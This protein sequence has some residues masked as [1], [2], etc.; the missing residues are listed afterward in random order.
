[1]AVFKMNQSDCR[2]SKT[3]WATIPVQTLEDTTI[4]PRAHSLLMW[5]IA[6][7]AL[8]AF[9]ISHIAKQFNVSRKAVSAWTTELVKAEY[10]DRSQVQINGRYVWSYYAYPLKKPKLD[11]VLHTIRV[12]K[13]AKAS[14]RKHSNV[15]PFDVVE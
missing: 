13:I 6:K 3:E 12:N 5:M 7:P 15:I 9:S 14:E 2:I 8:W 1:M 11:A 10:V 4:S